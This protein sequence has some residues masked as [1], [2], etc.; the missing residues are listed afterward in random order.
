MK[1][2]ETLIKNLACVAVVGVLSWLATGCVSQT[3]GAFRGQGSSTVVTLSG[4]NYKL[5]KPEAKGE[6]KGFSL[7]LGLIPISSPQ[8]ANAKADLYKSVGEP[9]NGRSI[10]LV[11]LTV[12]KGS[13]SF[14]LFS[15]PILTITADVLEF[16]DKAPSK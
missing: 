1:Q 2:T 14:I 8:Y 3:G 12:D 11:N 4:N 10:A 15:I 9:L 13:R 5:I 7:L 16:T 6:S